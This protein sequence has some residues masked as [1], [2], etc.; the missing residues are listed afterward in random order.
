[1]RHVVSMHGQKCDC[2]HHNSVQAARELTSFAEVLRIL[3]ADGSYQQ[4]VQRYA[5][6]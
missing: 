1:M 2:Q 6:S 4:I 3:V 5:T